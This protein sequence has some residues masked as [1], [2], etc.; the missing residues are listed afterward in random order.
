[1]W[2]LLHERLYLLVEHC[3][4]HAAEGHPAV[5]AARDRAAAIAERLAAHVPAELR[6]LV[7]RE[8]TH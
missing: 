4:V 1:V 8:K 5:L 6:P 3:S 2:A 7:S